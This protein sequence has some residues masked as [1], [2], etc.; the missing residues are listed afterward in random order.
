[1]VERKNRICP[2]RSFNVPT[3]VEVP[4]VESI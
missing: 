3:S 2:K 4:E 1:M